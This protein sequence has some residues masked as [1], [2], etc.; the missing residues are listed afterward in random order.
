MIVM[1]L[2]RQ[3]KIA[4]KKSWWTLNRRE[5]DI[6]GPFCATYE[7]GDPRRADGME[8][9]ARNDRLRIERLELGPW[10]TN[11][12]VVHC[13]RTDKCALIDVPP[14]LPAIAQH[15]G[16]NLPE[17]VLLTHNHIDHIAGLGAFKDQFKSPVA[18]HELDQ[19][20]FGL[21]PEK[22]LR[23][24]DRLF[25]GDLE[26]AVLH[27]P[28][29]TPGSLCFR[30][31]DYLIAGDTLFPGGP[32]RTA[33]PAD[34]EQILA[35]I[36]AKILTLDDGVRVFPGHGAATDVGSAKQEYEYFAAQPHR[37]DLCGDVEWR[38]G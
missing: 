32:G 16:A 17:I 35:S 13:V 20:G 14:D 7:L 2:L 15:L 12:Y 36:R 9:V 38:T 10:S 18:G 37:A 25:L 31:Q 28:G 33:T 4:V 19:A 8:V 24:G 22:L 1:K 11:C 23:E 34:F 26:I 30:T 29:H 5:N 21:K 3:H 27:T 6:I